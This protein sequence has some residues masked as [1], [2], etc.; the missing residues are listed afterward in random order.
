MGVEV[1]GVD[2]LMMMHKVSLVQLLPVAYL[3][4]IQSTPTV[5]S[6]SHAT[7]FG[8]TYQD[9]ANQFAVMA[10][11][12]EPYMAA[13]SRSSAFRRNSWR[14]GRRIALER[15][16]AATWRRV[17]VGKS[18]IASHTGD[19]LAAERA[20]RPGTSTSSASTTA[21]NRRQDEL[22]LPLRLPGRES[23]RRVRDG[24]GGTGEDRR[25]VPCRRDRV[26][27]RRAVRELRPP[28]RRPPRRRPSFRASS[29]RSATSAR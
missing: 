19:D 13:L 7:W 14:R 21:G 28:K 4:D 25:P 10:V 23:P 3:K 18:A 15:S 29:T 2:R 20:A 6:A 12:P 11:D 1:A 5:Q 17:T 9:N 24:R 8:G 22:L 26:E 27:P 16:S